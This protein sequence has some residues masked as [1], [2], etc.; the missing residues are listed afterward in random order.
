M[1]ASRTKLRRDC[2]TDD[3]SMIAYDVLYRV[4]LLNQVA[5]ESRLPVIKI[6][7]SKLLTSIRKRL[8]HEKAKIENDLRGIMT[9]TPRF[10]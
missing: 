5:H 7:K 1:R 4:Q 3:V 2:A 6:R 10:T 8:A 9:R